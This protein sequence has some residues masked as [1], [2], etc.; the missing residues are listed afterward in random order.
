MTSRFFLCLNLDFY[1]PSKKSL[2]I[3]TDKKNKCIGTF[4]IGDAMFK[5]QFGVI[6]KNLRNNRKK[7]KLSLFQIALTG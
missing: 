1:I 5:N 2:P 4:T 6:G 3:N 7:N